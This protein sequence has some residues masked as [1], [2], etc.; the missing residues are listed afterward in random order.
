MA[1]AQIYPALGKTVRAKHGG[2]IPPEGIT[3]ELADPYY[4]RRLAESG[5]TTTP[6]GGDDPQP[7]LA[8][9]DPEPA[10]TPSETALQPGLKKPRKGD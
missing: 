7:A 9:T 1:R 8:E 5:I 3:V 6:P 4:Q 10:P 2:K